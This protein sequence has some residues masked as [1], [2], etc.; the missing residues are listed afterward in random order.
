[1]KRRWTS[2]IRHHQMFSKEISCGF[3]EVDK[4]EKQAFT[5][6]YLKK[7]KKSQIH[8]DQPK[9]VKAKLMWGTVTALALRML[10]NQT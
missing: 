2:S 4:E 3:L 8:S 1:M 5:C 10:L 9:K 7:K 6:Q